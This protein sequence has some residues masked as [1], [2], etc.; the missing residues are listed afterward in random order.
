MLNFAANLSWLFQ[1]WSFL[2]RFAAAADAGFGAVEY[3]FPYDHGPD[4]IAG[5]LSRHGLKQVLFNLPP[6]DFAAGE[7][8]IAALPGRRDEFRASV[9]TA[10]A[11]ARTLGAPRLHLMSG[12]AS[13]DGALAAYRD[14]LGFACD[15]AAR[16]GIDILIE[17]INNRDIPG[18]LMNNFDLAQ[19]IIGELALPNLKLQFDIYHR[20]V[21]HGDVT[22][23]LEALM[24]ITGHIQIAS[25]PLRQEPGSGELDDK[26][27]LQTI[28]GLGYKG[29]I[30]CEYRPAAGT[31]AG[32]GW[33]QRLV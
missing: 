20:Q 8:G 12:I 33:M 11:Y 4:V 14:A 31:L 25:A 32:L 10:L 30:G 29:H 21:I 27:I 26:R 23:G 16:D 5:L 24:P 1:E 28:R 3:L 22:R 18:Y 7:R 19:Q 2:D 6:G 17:P 13:G 15:A 9:A